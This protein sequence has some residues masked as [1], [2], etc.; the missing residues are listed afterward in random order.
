MTAKGRL[1]RD[2]M[3]FERSAT[4]RDRYALEIYVLLAFNAIKQ[5]SISRIDFT[6]KFRLAE[7]MLM[8]VVDLRAICVEND[9]S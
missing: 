2:E 5:R 8:S 6:N 3:C 1:K 9:Q 4:A 7:I